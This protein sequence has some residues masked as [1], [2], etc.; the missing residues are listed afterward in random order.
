MY[1]CFRHTII[2]LAL[3]ATGTA[4]LPKSDLEQ[5][6]QKIQALLR[7]GRFDEAEP[8]VRECIRQLPEEIYFL[9]QLEM[10]LNGEGKFRE[11]DELRDKIRKLWK[12][13][14]QEKW[15]AKGSPVGES[16]WARVVGSSK[17][18]DVFGVEYFVPRLIEGSDRKDPLALI[19]YYKVIALPKAVNGN[20]RVL[21]L[22]KSASEKRYFLEEFSG[23]AVTMAKMYGNEI[24]DIRAVVA[25]A[26]AYLDRTKDKQAEF[27]P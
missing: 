1:A 18:Y 17:E 20:S 24:P 12:K 8:L 14:Y 11:A 25:D 7:S 6:S 22:D 2:L 3:V 9:G 27:R 19:A 16:S 13:D 21:Q 26:I 15:V 4:Q 10:V 23:A 5:K